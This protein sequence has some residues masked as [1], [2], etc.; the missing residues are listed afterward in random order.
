MHEWIQYLVV[1]DYYRDEIR[2]F[3]PTRIEWTEALSESFTPPPDG[4]TKQHL[5]DEMEFQRTA[6][7]RCFIATATYGSPAEPEID[8]HRALT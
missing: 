8:T 1:H 5:A 4:N 7:S 6:Q 3:R 2:M